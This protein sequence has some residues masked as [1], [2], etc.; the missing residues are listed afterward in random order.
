MLIYNF[1][2]IIAVIEILKIRFRM[3]RLFRLLFRTFLLL[4]LHTLTARLIDLDLAAGQCVLSKT[5]IALV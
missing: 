4:L 2:V 3:R 5:I 1:F